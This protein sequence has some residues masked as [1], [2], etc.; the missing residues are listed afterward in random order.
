MTKKDEYLKK[1]VI[2]RLHAVPPNVSFSIGSYGEFTRDE[3]IKE[4]EE[5]TKIG[6]ETI[7]MQVNFIK[8]MPKMKKLLSSTSL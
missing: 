7:R 5:D 8:K 3:L 6:E 1:L 2:E 4:V